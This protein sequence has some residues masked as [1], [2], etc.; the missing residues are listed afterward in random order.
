MKI[1][2]YKTIDI[3]SEVH[4]GVDE[5]REALVDALAASKAKTHPGANDRQRECPVNQ[6]VNALW[7]CLVAIDEE[8]LN[9]ISPES[10]EVIANALMRKARMFGAKE[11]EGV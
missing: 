8:M 1:K 10:R 6:F 5:I 11:T 3:E 2:F 4:I 9:Q 7:T